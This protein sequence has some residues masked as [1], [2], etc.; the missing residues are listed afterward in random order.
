MS[1]QLLAELSGVTITLLCV[2][3]SIL[4]IVLILIMIAYKTYNSLVV[5]QERYKN[6]W[7]QIDV[8]LRRRHD[9]IPSL[10]ETVK[11][12]MAHE[13]ET[14]D[15]VISARNACTIKL[16]GLDLSDPGALQ[17]LMG[18]ENMLTG[19]LSK[20][21]AVSEAYP[22]LKANDTMGNLQEELSSTENRISFA[23]QGYN[24]SV[25]SFNIT[26]KAFPAVLFSGMFGFSADAPFWEIEDDSVREAPDVKFT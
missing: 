7:S 4:L 21:M 23:R 11:G 20:L 10:V 9:L 16:D 3:A 5:G 2:G 26:R 13:K 24:D 17:G 22:D 6:Q 8:Q 14:L 19:A 12:Y 1:Y 18:A 25:Q 15:A